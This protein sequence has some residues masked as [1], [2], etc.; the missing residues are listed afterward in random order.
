[1][2]GKTPIGGLRTLGAPGGTQEPTP[3]DD[4]QQALAEEA[5]AIIRAEFDKALQLKE[6]LVQESSDT[7]PDKLRSII[8]SLEG[9]NRF[10]IAMRIIT[11]AE[12][13][14]IFADAIKR[15]LYEGWR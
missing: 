4:A 13:R 5:L 15:G 6:K 8:A 7:M 10:A 12:S 3:R 14:Q 1:M 11:P 9:M 2:T